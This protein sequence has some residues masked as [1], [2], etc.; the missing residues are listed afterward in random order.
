MYPSRKTR[1]WSAFIFLSPQEV[2]EKIGREAAGRTHCPREPELNG[3]YWLENLLEIPHKRLAATDYKWA[4]RTYLL[5][6]FYTTLE[7][8]LERGQ[9]I[10]VPLIKD[11]SP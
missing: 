5:A 8:H 4:L 6:S 9:R 7:N 2:I 10:D 3:T 1:N 11:D